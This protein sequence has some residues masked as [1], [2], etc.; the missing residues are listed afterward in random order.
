[1]KI[2]SVEWARMTHWIRKF[3]MDQRTVEHARGRG[4]VSKCV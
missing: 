4:D 1:M 3:E 2:A